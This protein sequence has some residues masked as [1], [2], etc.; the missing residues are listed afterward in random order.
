[1]YRAKMRELGITSKHGDCSEQQTQELE[2]TTG[3]SLPSE[4][5]EFLLNFGTL[6][7]HDQEI[8]FYPVKSPALD[9]NVATEIPIVN[10]YD[11][12]HDEYDISVLFARY[13]GRMPDE[14]MPIAECPDGDQ[15]CIGLNKEA[16]GRI[17]I[18]PQYLYISGLYLSIIM[19]FFRLYYSHLN[20]IGD[21]G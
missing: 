2:Q 7:F 8:A 14:I 17:T 16:S 3:I 13:K 18:S 19:Q 5:K 20:I 4:Y 10:F 21:K 11:L 15:L 1:M 9:V 12:E 6:D